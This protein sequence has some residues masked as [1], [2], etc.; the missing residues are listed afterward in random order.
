M[1]GVWIADV[2]PLYKEDRYQRFYQEVP[3]FRKQKADRCDSIQKKAQSV[4]AWCLLQRIID[5]YKWGEVPAFNLSHSGDYVLCAV[6]MD[7]KKETKIGCDIQQMKQINLK[8]AERFFCENEYQRIIEQPTKEKQYDTFY[9]YWVLKESYVKAT[10]K[11]LSQ[12]IKSFEVQLSS[13]PKLVKKS[14]D[15]KAYYYH[16]FDFARLPYK[17]A[18]CSDQKEICPTVKREFMDYFYE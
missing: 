6:D 5:C 9:R 13:P 4:G 3:D 7:G 12:G 10:R 18:V 15:S 16:E 17:I 2:T 1:V 11:G 14:K 8:I